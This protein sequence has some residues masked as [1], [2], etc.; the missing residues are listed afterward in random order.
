MGFHRVD[1]GDF[2]LLED[3]ILVE[4]DVMQFETSVSTV[5]TI[6]LVL[7]LVH[8]VSQRGR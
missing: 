8:D 7:Y 6:D 5:N 1:L 4:V 3:A 2:F